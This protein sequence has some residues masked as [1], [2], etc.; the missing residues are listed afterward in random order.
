MSGE[1]LPC[2]K[3]EGKA[4]YEPIPPYDWRVYCGRF[5]LK[6]PSTPICSTS[7]TA[8]EVWNLY[9]R[10]EEE[11]ANRLEPCECGGVAG[12]RSM[13]DGVGNHWVT[14]YTCHMCGASRVSKE[15]ARDE[16][17]RIQRKL[18]A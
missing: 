2:P 15:R 13:H 3:C 9:A 5:L 12:P 1:L 7:D 8:R 16:W 6:H 18:K 10:L 14:C 11:H 17:N 4:E